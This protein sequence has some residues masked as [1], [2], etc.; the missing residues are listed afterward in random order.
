MGKCALSLFYNVF[1]YCREVLNIES[2]FTE[3]SIKSKLKSIREFG[4]SFLGIVGKAPSEI[5]IS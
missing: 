3:N 2:L 4:P 1:T 5:R